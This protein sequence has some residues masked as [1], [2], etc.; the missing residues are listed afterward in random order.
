LYK[1]RLLLAYFKED[2]IELNKI[3]I[4]S[5]GGAVSIGEISDWEL[6]DFYRALIKLKDSP[7]ISYGILMI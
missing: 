6:K 1:T 3:Q 7:E 4:P 5:S 2:E